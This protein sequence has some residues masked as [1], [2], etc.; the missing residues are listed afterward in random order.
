MAVAG[1][2][3][4]RPIVAVAA[5]LGA[6][7][8][9][10]PFDREVLPWLESRAWLRH[11]VANWLVRFPLWFV[12]IG[13]AVAMPQDLDWR[14]WSLAAVFAVT[15]FA[16]CWG[17]LIWVSQK[18]GALRPAPE[19]LRRI[20]AETSSR[21]G[22]SVRC[23]WLLRS[24]YSLAFALP[25]TGELLFTERLL[26]R[27]PDEE[28]SAICAHELGHLKESKLIVVGRV[29]ANLAWLMP[30]LF[31]KPAMHAFDPP[32]VVVFA[33]VGLA[34][35]I[36]NRWF[37]RHLEKRADLVAHSNEG[38]TGAYARAL[39]RLY[40]DNLVPAVL[41]RRGRS[42]PDLY[43]RLLAMGV[44]PDFE[45]PKPAQSN[46]AHVFVLLLVL[47]ILVALRAAQLHP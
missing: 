47:G 9:T 7:A 41:P 5:W 46:A 33:L 15:F 23:V 12:L 10:Y 30:W 16:W 27:H 25:Y 18:L 1:Q 2:H 39:A 36:G 35:M 22:V 29:L 8:G 43:D 13:I 21:M 14:G 11:V 4:S 6:V 28:I 42:H 45:R 38:E 34:M 24:A 3:R 17:G 31:I 40:E 32:G 44:Q 20:V 19:R 37:V 26:E